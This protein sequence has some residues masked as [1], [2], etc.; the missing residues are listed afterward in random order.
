MMGFPKT[1]NIPLVF[2]IYKAEPNQLININNLKI[3][4]RNSGSDPLLRR[5]VFSLRGASPKSTAIKPLPH[6]LL[7]LHH[8]LVLLH[9][10]TASQHR[11]VAAVVAAQRVNPP[12]ADDVI[13]AAAGA[14]RPRRDRRC[15][16]P[17]LKEEEAAA[18]PLPPQRLLAQH[19]RNLVHR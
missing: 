4:S 19:R 8:L 6:L 15:F 10:A 17:G 14:P 7:Q 11:H 2:S 16:L 5:R 3:M 9:R 13:A 12:G 18:P 1:H